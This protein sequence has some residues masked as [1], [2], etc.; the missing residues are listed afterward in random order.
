MVQITSKFID[1]L[2]GGKIIED[3]NQKYGNVIVK[4]SNNSIDFRTRSLDDISGVLFK[5]NRQLADFALVKIKRAAE[6]F[7]SKFNYISSFRMR[8]E[9]TYTQRSV[10]ERVKP[11][12][13]YTIDQIFDWKSKRSKD[14]GKLIKE[15]RELQLMNLLTINKFRGGRYEVRV[16]TNKFGAWASLAD[17]G[18]GISQFLP[19]IVADLQLPKDSTIVIDQPEIHLHPRA[20]AQLADYF[21]RQINN[22]E[23][24]YIIETHSELH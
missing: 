2:S 8:P 5:E 6:E 3:Y 24:K 11:N 14:F 12:G 19:L 9:R 21:I 23:K 13:D 4:T 22:N 17:V 18:F 16:K 20:Q 10:I 7:D 1:Q 15:L